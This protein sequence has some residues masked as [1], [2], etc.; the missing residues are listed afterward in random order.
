MLFS[1]GGVA[2]D[3]I[4]ALLLAAAVPLAATLPVHAVAAQAAS[5]AGA[6]EPP[7]SYADL[8]DL[9]LAAPVIVDAT[10]RSATRI[11]G[12][13]AAAL[14]PGLQRF[15]VEADVAAL[16]RGAAGLPPRIGYVVDVPTDARGRAPKLR[17]MRVLAFAQ[18]VLGSAD[19]VQL[20]APRAQLGWSPSLDASVREI[21]RA[22]LTADAPP[23]ITGIASAFHVAGSLPGEGETQVFAQTADRQPVS[24]SILRRPGEA[25][26]WS[27]ALGEIVDEAA[28]PP[29]RDT[30]LWYRLACGLPAALPDASV[31]TLAPDDA[32]IA[33]ADYRF[34]VESLGPCGRSRLA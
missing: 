14:A 15:Y 1:F 29:A 12:A 11:K 23:A 27:V 8:A 5:P 26:R 16:V 32:A 2:G 3:M 19:Q 17:K 6:V 21:A 9:V 20:V 25:P 31:A 10:I 24:L 34:V 22:A 4:R 30:L 33:R 13:E 28:P 18:P 7:P